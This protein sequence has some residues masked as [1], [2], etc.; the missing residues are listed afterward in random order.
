MA[1]QPTVFLVE[2][3]PS[4]LNALMLS[5]KKRGLSVVGY[6]SAEDFLQSYD[7][8]EPGCLVLDLRLT[9]MTGLELQQALIQKQAAIPIIFISGHGDIPSSVN[10]I[11]GGAVDFLEKPIRQDVLL[12]RIQ[13]ALAEDARNRQAD[14]E[15]RHIKERFEQL[16]AREREVLALLVADSV[17][18]SSKVIARKLDISP[19]TVESHRARIMDKMQAKSIP[20]LV[21]MAKTCGV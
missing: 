20:D 18:T 14:L 2:D 4:V 7:P 13:E 19:R 11:K 9:G 8:T 12:E 21:A 1:S 15:N 6:P 5:L 17:E 3:D 16:T 10:A